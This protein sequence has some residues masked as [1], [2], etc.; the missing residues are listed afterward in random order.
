MLT[1]PDMQARYVAATLGVIEA[2]LRKIDAASADRGA[3]FAL[4]SGAAKAAARLADLLAQPER[5]PSH[6]AA[7]CRATA[8]VGSNVIAFRR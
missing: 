6:K 4:V 7:P 3:L 1:E 5:P 2:E 8:A